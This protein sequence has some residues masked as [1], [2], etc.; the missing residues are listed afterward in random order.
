MGDLQDLKERVKNIP[1][2]VLVLAG[3]LLVLAL[4][5]GG[6][7]MMQS[8][9][10]L[11]SDSSTD[12]VPVETTQLPGEPTDDVIPVIPDEMGGESG[13]DEEFDGMEDMVEGPEGL[14]ASLPIGTTVYVGD[15]DGLPIEFTITKTDVFDVTGSCRN[16]KDDTPIELNA[17]S[18]PAMAGDISFFGTANGHNWSFYLT[19]EADNITGTANDEDKEMKVTLRKK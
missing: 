12:V 6:Y 8:D 18:L 11:S 13:D 3:L 2:V 4:A 16:V 14:I 19:G 10:A 9:T 15:M 1:A 7:S 5:F 17:E